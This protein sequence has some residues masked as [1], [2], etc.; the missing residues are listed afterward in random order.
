MKPSPRVL[1]AA[2]VCAAALAAPLLLSEAQVSVYV[3]LLLAACVVTG[4]SMLM[5]YAGQV[6]LGQASFFMVGGYTAALITTHGRPSWLGLAAAPLVAAAL[7]ALIGVPLLRLRGH[8]LAFATLAVQLI[9][10]NLVGQQ[11]WTGGDIGLQGV[12]R[13]EIAGYEFATDLSYAYLALAALG[14]IALITRNIV[15]SRPG[16]GLRALA[17]SEVAAASSGV[18]VAT[19]KLAVFSLSAGFAGLAGGIYA[20]YIGYVAPGSFPV[21]L[22]FEYVVMVVVGG[23]GTV[24]G[25]LA[26]ATVITLLLQLLN[27]VGTMEGMPAAAPTV[28]SYAVY[29]L[30]LI[31]IVLFMPRGLVPSATGWWERRAARGAPAS[32]EPDAAPVRDLARTS[33]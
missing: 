7:A 25:A 16:R 22:S 28:L 31:L 33:P 18:P 19:Y 6:S 2:A 12:P 15:A 10:L 14:L 4:L 26:G 11:E 13:L 5:G 29:G 32:D 8:Q 1:V 24:Y 20:F 23:A 9:L 21:L 27:N 3:L 17:T 30:L